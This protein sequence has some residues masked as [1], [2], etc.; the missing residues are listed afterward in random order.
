MFSVSRAALEAARVRARSAGQHPRRLEDDV[1]RVEE[2]EAHVAERQVELLGGPPP[3]GVRIHHHPQL[4]EAREVVEVLAPR[5]RPHDSHGLEAEPASGDGV[6]V[7]LGQVGDVLLWGDRKEE[8]GGRTLGVLVLRT[9]LHRA[10]R[11]EP[12]GIEL[13]HGV[14][15][16][17][18]TPT[19]RL[20]ADVESSEG[21]SVPTPRVLRFQEGLHGVRPGLR[22]ERLFRALHPLRDVAHGRPP[23]EN[24]PAALARYRPPAGIRAAPTRAGV[25]PATE[26]SLTHLGP[27]VNGESH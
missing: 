7:P 15:D 24:A 8:R 20:K 17:W 26:A 1:G 13:P 18:Q 14:E 19:V 3:R 27:I 9:F 5:A 12:L 25:E 6:R 16:G 23:S 11:V 21:L 22:P 2:D 10:L 4:A